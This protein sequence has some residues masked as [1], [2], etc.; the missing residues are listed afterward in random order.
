MPTTP[1][2]NF[3]VNFRWL[4]ANILYATLIDPNF[5]TQFH[6]APS[7]KIMM[8]KLGYSK[9]HISKLTQLKSTKLSEEE[10]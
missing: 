7:K 1:T 10:Q 2:T 9:A 3:Q 4:R 6:L 8:N 5:C